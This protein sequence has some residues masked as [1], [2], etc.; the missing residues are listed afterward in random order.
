MR[1]DDLAALGQQI[2]AQRRALGLTQVV[3]AG[4]GGVSVALW[5]DLERGKRENVSVGTVLRILQTLGLD[6]ELTPRRP[7][8]PSTDRAVDG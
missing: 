6:L 7:P 4:L 5:S 1:I 8:P 3:A 2:R